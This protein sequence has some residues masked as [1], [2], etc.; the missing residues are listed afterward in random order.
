MDYTDFAAR[1]PREVIKLNH[2]LIYEY[3]NTVKHIFGHLGFSIYSN[4]NIYIW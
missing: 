2:S 3:F 1:Y 4:I